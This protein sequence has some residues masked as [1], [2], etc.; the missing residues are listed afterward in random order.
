MFRGEPYLVE[1]VVDEA[2]CIKKWRS[3]MLKIVTVAFNLMSCRSE[4][5]CSEVS[6]LGEVR[7]I[8]LV[9]ST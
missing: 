6:R 3:V 2:H 5:F 9:E 8:C 7:S 4:S 1:F